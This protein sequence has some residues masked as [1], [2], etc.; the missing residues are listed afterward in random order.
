MAVELN[1]V[2]LLGV[3]LMACRLGGVFLLSPVLGFATL[4]PTFR[5]IFV[6]L[7][8]VVMAAPAGVRLPA[9]IGPGE[10]AILAV[11]ALF[12][13]AL[14]GAALRAAIAA[15]GFGGQLIDFQVGFNAAAILNPATEVQSTLIGVLL[16][17]FGTLLFLV[18]DLHLV[19]L[20]GLAEAFGQA[21]TGFGTPSGL[22]QTVLAQS[23]LTFTFGLALVMPVVVGLFLI[24]ATIAVL[25][26]SMPQINIYFVALPVKVFAGLALFAASLRFLLPLAG[27]ILGLALQGLQPASS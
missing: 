8:S 10:L 24:D 27:R 9:A 11:G 13:G 20:R 6:I 5:V 25:S 26:R 16:E 1:P 4:P 12:Q 18:L 7:M 2:W 22:L 21:Q 14:I 19:L 17:M 15:F 3:F 23:S